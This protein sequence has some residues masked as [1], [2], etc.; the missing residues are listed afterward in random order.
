MRAGIYGRLSVVRT[1]D[2]DR[3][4]L[5]TSTDRQVRD[6]FEWVHRQAGEV[7]RTYRD[8]GISGYTGARRPDFERLL[9]DVEGGVIDTIVCWKLDRLCRNH[10]DFQRL[11]E[12]CEAHGARLVSLH[13]M[14]DSSTPAG[15]M[16][17]RMTIGMAKMESDNIS[18]RVKRALEAARQAG[19]L[20]TGG[21]RTFGYTTGGEIVAAEAEIVRWAAAEILAGASI[22]GLEATLAARGVV[23]TLG[24]PIGR[25]ALKRILTAPRTAALV[26]HQGVIVGEGRWPPLL[27]RPTWEQVRSV[28]LSSSRARE[29]R[30]R[31]WL[32]VGFLFCGVEGC[33]G[34][35]VSRPLSTRG[36]RQ[37]SYVCMATGR[38]HLTV[39][40][41]PV[42]KLIEERVLDRLDHRGLAGVL[43]T[44]DAGNGE[45][46]LAEQLTR[47]DEALKELGDDYYQRRL[48]KKPEFLRQRAALEQRIAQTR[49]KLDRLMERADLAGLPTA[50]GAL[51][52]AWPDMTLAARRAVLGLVLERVV[53]LPATGPRRTLDPGRVV[54]PPD[55]WR[56]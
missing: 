52:K 5:E 37:P 35:L 47:D 11:W 14:F 40:S 8:E 36:N 9:A 12:V 20:H 7:V 39:S 1:Q 24:R 22:R 50:P 45:R 51:R 34:K 29:Q 21:G 27:D 6:C 38:V 42:D 53:I 4:D 28:L 2:D 32:L 41:P 56:A 19:R 18:L 30:P 54:I 15:E 26:E 48:I 49:A 3:R 13:E 44:L 17:M 31:R 16:A 25:R 23:G 33:G 55:A 46:E 10:R 43:A